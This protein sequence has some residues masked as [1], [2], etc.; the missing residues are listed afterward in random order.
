M[1]KNELIQISKLIKIL[2]EREVSNAQKPLLQEIKKLQTSINQVN[3]LL[4]ENSKMVKSSPTKPTS[5][6][7]R[8]L[9]FSINDILNEVEDDYEVKPKQKLFKNSK[10]PIASIFEDV[11]PFNENSEDVES[12]LDYMNDPKLTRSNDA[13]S[14][15]LN[16]LQNTDFRKKLQIMENSANR[17]NMSEMN[18]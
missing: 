7:G 12:V 4:A 11:T 10:S 13:V 17:H 2:I 18:R 14:K 6:N 9:N 3:Q 8:S 1:T 15:V 16:T 5:T